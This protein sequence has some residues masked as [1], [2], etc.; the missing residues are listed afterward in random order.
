MALS[1]YNPINALNASS[2]LREREKK[3]TIIA[4]TAVT[5]ILAISAFGIYKHKVKADLLPEYTNDCGRYEP[6]PLHF[7]ESYNKIFSNKEFQLDLVS[8]LQGAIQIDTEVYDDYGQPD[9]SVPLKDE[10]TYGKFAPLHDYLEKSF[11]L[12]HKHFN[13]ELVNGVN[14][15]FTLDTKK[16]KVSGKPLL[17]MAHQDVVPVNPDT[18]DRWTY[19]PFDGIYEPDTGKIF[20]RGS[21]DT[22]KLLIGELAAVELLLADGFEF[23]RP[24]VIAFGFDEEKGGE[25]GAQFI[26][27]HLLKKYGKNGIEVVLDEGGYVSYF[28]ENGYLAQPGVAEKGYV[29]IEIT[30]NTLGG[31]SSAPNHW[32]IETTGIGLM[33]EV[34]VLLTE[35]PFPVDIAL[36]NP[37]LDTLHCT[38]KYQPKTLSKDLLKAVKSNR[39]SKLTAALNNSLKKFTFKT[40]QAI[41]IIKGGVKSNAMPEQVVNLVNHR[42]NLKSSVLETVEHDLSAV[43]QVADKYDVGISLDWNN[44]TVEVL[45]EDS[46]NGGFVVK[47]VNSLEPVPRT[48]VDAIWDL[49]A[50]TYSTVYLHS[51]FSNPEHPEEVQEVYFEGSMNTGNT[52]TKYYSHYELVSGRIYRFSG[53]I[54]EG[55]NAHTVDE[56]TTEKSL[57]STTG[58]FYAFVGNFN[59]YVNEL[60]I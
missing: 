17:L 30:L 49:I 15:V 42:I 35:D 21:S 48:P 19:P 12:V 56:W 26:A 43:T 44:G 51:Y 58:F 11:P 6:L 50:G 24:L 55:A 52:D 32:D 22:K 46:V 29:D 16:H 47:V 28:G 5:A 53:G 9:L 7:T 38:S 40:T 33:S 2:K 8:K 13:K 59:G 39:I 3:K 45:K 31:H 4:A 54:N 18:I 41:D 25:F 60:D 20:G 23:N 57:V 37:I 34:N 27:K 36:N 1:D 10:P 14:L